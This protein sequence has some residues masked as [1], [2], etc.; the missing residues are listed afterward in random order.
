MPCRGSTRPARTILAV[1]LYLVGF[2]VLL[3]V[4]SKV[5]L[6]PALIAR[7]DA[8]PQQKKVLA[9]SSLLVMAVVL[10]VLLMGLLIAFRIGRFF[11]PRRREQMKPTQYVD[12][13][14]EAGRRMQVPEEE[15]QDEDENP[16]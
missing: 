8:T 1:V 14:K 7:Q 6:I 5:Y 2:E 10:F 3:M 13:W 4:V 16:S 11:F 9:A 15:N 12:A